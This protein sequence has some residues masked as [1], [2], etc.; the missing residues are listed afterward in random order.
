MLS[1]MRL[2]LGTF[3]VSSSIANEDICILISYPYPTFLYS[4]RGD[5]PTHLLLNWMTSLDSSSSSS[6]SSDTYLSLP[7][8][9]TAA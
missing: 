8:L 1:S 6:E 9:A 5:V 7:L 2:T 3:R 4:G